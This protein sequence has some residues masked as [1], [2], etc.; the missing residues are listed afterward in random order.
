MLL[1]IIEV[2]RVIYHRKD[3]RITIIAVWKITKT[4]NNK[5]RE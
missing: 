4:C 5:D 2:D 3:Q 1:M